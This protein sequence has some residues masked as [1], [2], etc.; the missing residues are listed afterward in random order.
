MRFMLTVTDTHHHNVQTV[1]VDV[2]RITDSILDG[3]SVLHGIE[4][5]LINLETLAK[6]SPMKPATIEKLVLQCPNQDV[7]IVAKA[8]LENDLKMLT[9]YF[10]M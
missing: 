3:A 4:L 1:N 8:I 9:D 2:S 5:A 6:Y 7:S 10:K